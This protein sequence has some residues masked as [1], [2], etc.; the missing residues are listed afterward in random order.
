VTGMTATLEAP[1]TEHCGLWS[2]RLLQGER[3][4]FH[5]VTGRALGNMAP[6]RPAAGDASRG[7]TRLASTLGVDSAE[8][9]FP[10]I[11]HGA[12]VALVERDGDVLTRAVVQC[13]TPRVAIE[14]LPNSYDALITHVKGAFLAVAV[15]DCAPVFIYD[16][17]RE[18]IA[19]AHAGIAGT[20]YGVVPHTVSVMRERYGSRPADIVVSIGPCISKD[21]LDVLGSR[22]WNRVLAPKGV[23]TA[24]PPTALERVDGKLLFDIP[25]C[26][27][28]D[29]LGLGV[30]AAQIEASK[31]CT[32]R[33]RASFFSDYAA[34]AEGPAS[35]AAEGRFLAIIGMR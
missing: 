2:S 8:V 23:L 34:A 32:V 18:V 31:L 3:G 29:L 24:L 25:G 33:R 7:E 30:P 20:A 19:L 4:L 5:A 9:V 16:Q 28:T 22:M 6:S 15:A 35:R 21:C 26:I 13:S 1:Y 27:R 17:R 11:A 12:A 10:R 14:P